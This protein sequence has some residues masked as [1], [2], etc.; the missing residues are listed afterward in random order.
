MPRAVVTGGAGFIG[1]HDVAALLAEGVEVTLVD[2]LSSGDRAKL[3]GRAEFRRV[4][5]FDGPTLD[6]VI[7]EAEP[8]AIYHLAAQSSVTVS[9]TDPSRDCARARRRIR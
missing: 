3:D 7:D 5:I 2:D 4:D 8:S 1:S 6:S 9:V